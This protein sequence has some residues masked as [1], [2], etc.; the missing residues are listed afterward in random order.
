MVQHTQTIHQHD[1]SL[2][3]SELSVR[4]AFKG[5]SLYNIK[6]K[7]IKMSLDFAVF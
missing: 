6:I 3:V 7:T 4:L 2:S 1:N 5:L